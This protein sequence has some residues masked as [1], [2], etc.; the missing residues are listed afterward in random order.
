MTKQSK[1]LTIKNK[2]KSFF[3]ELRERIKICREAVGKNY[4]SLSEKI[5]NL[6]PAKIARLEYG[7]DVKTLPLYILYQYAR[8]L[9]CEIKIQ[10]IQRLER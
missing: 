10:I 5:P 2:E 8:E 6:S 9:G 1:Q 3:L 7:N 4:D